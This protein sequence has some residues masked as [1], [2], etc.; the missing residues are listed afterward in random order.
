M[1]D[2]IRTIESDALEAD[3]KTAVQERDPISSFARCFE[4]Q[5]RERERCHGCGR[6]IDD[7][8]KYCSREHYA[9]LTKHSR[10][11]NGRWYYS[12]ECDECGV[13]STEE[14]VIRY[15][16]SEMEL[17]DRMEHEFPVHLGWTAGESRFLRTAALSTQ[18][19]APE[20][21]NAPECADDKTDGLPF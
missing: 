21:G 17:R 18:W 20:D 15:R 9:P 1:N 16:Y 19:T 5:L 2:E 6:H 3:A 8:E 14:I 11:R 10:L 7:L 13:M 12:W 4:R